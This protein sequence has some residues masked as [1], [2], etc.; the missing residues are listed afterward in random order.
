MKLIN[1]FLLKHFLKILL[2]SCSAF[3][4]IYVLIDFFEKVGDFLEHQAQF[5]DYFTYLFN[6]IPLIFV[7]ILPLAVLMTVVL[8]LGGLGRTNEVTAMR[9]C[10]ISLWKI[11]QPFM[12]LA[13][14]LSLLL[15]LLNEFV[16]PYNAKALHQ[17]LEIKLK[18]KT[19][20]NLLHNEVWYRNDGRIF[21]IISVDPKKKEMQGVTVFFIDDKARLLQRIETPLL[22]FNGDTWVA[23]QLTV[24]T[25]DPETGDLL[26]TESKQ[27]QMMETGRRPK[28]FSLA[29]N[30]TDELNLRQLW[31]MTRKLEREGYAATRQRVAMYSRLAAPFTCLVM[32]FL[33]VPFA[34][35]KGRRS[36]IALGIGLSLGIGVVYF[37]LQSL[38]TAFGNSGALPP[39][40]AAWSTNLIF[41]MGGVWLLLSV[42]E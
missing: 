41:L 27:Q 32:A 24:R 18:G 3:I 30:R 9:A 28:D 38:L 7:Q 5:K 37:I 22:R 34:L 36:N 20:Q 31:R 16:S 12:G 35:Q 19:P 15:L 14:L 11:V 42:K 25:F 23:E 21:N 1:L 8:T 33:G 13:L 39:L 6:S 26:S 29:E 4:S 17:L 10:G 2:L 40:L